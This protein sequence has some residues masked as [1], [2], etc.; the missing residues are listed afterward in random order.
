MTIDDLPRTADGSTAMAFGAGIDITAVPTVQALS[1]SFVLRANEAPTAT[2]TVGNPAGP[3]AAVAGSV[4]A[5]DQGNGAVSYGPELFSTAKGGLVCLD[6]VSGQF[7]YTPSDQARQLARTSADRTHRSDSFTVTVADRYGRRTEVPVT[8]QVAAAKVAPKAVTRVRRPDG[9]GVVRGRVEAT[10]C[11]GGKVRY[12]LVNSSNPAGATVESAYSQKGGLVQLDPET[13]RF[14]FVPAISSAV[15][16]ALD[17]DSFVVTVF[18][19]HG[20]AV[21]VRVKTLAHLT[22]G[23]QTTSTSPNTQCGRLLIGAEVDV[24]VRLSVGTPPRKGTVRM[25]V[26]G[27]YIYVRSPGLGRDVP[28]V[29]EF[30]VTGT[31]HYGRSLTLATVRVCPP[32]ASRLL[33]GTADIEESWLSEV[34]EQTTRGR[35]DTVGADGGP[36]MFAG[37]AYI[38]TKGSRVIVEADGSFIYTSAGNCAVGHRAAAVDA[39][40]AD[41]VDTFTVGTVNWLGRTG[42]TVVR[43]DLLP[44][45]NAPMASTVGSSG[46]R[47][48]EMTGEWTTTVYDADGDDITFRVVQD[49][50][51]GVVSVRRD[52]QGGFVVNYRSTAVRAGNLYPR[53]RFAIRFYDGHVASDGT[54]AFVTTMYAF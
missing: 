28:A 25:G 4:T 21:H 35:I 45:N 9:N 29:D 16:P 40:A 44:Y 36:M 23:V 8:V 31:D 53:E 14:V 43:V 33:D 51:W 30:T 32:L 48:G 47:D 22:V 42:E 34:G 12:T 1:R 6:A 17:T 50:P 11:D 26:N 15:V 20:G 52:E 5:V 13:G 3:T 24:P 2:V 39:S 49:N 7:S 54:P 19:D 41:K 37:G 10:A 18:D 27:S 38:S 46:R